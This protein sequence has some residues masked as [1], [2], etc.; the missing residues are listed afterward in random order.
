MTCSTTYSKIKSAFM[1]THFFCIL[2]H[3]PNFK[4]PQQAGC[5]CTITTFNQLLFLISFGLTCVSH[6]AEDALCD[7][8]Y[9]V[10][11]LVI[12]PDGLSPWRVL[13][14]MLQEISQSLTHH[15]GCCAHLQYRR[16]TSST[17]VQCVLS[18]ITPCF[19]FHQA[20]KEAPWTHYPHCF[21]K[22]GCSA[23][24]A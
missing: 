2:S 3:L 21:L 23:W 19:L 13:A 5:G 14:N 15:A 8:H 4:S 9:G 22:T 6:G 1:S 11:G 7:G 20:G 10:C 18:C 12:A 17:L 24:T 16:C